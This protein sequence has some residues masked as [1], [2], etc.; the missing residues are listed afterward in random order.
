[1]TGSK[2]F[3][4][5]SWLA[6]LGRMRAPGERFCLSA[7]S[8]TSFTSPA[9]GR[10]RERSERER[11]RRRCSEPNGSAPSSRPSPRARGEG[12]RTRREAILFIRPR[13]HAGEGDHAKHGGGGTRRLVRSDRQSKRRRPRP[14]HRLLSRAVPLPRLAGQ[15][16]RYH[17]TKTER[18]GVA[19]SAPDDVQAMERAAVSR[20]ARLSGAGA[21]HAAGIL[22]RLHQRTLPPRAPLSRAA[23]VLLG[24][25]AG[26]AAGRMG[27][28]GSGLPAAARAVVARFAQRLGRPVV[29]LRWHSSAPA[30]SAGEGT[31]RSAVEGV[32]GGK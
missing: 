27:E 28:G 8:L 24:A 25:Q 10:G 22:A 19:V 20:A 6:K 16:G 2:S 30:R 18:A 13:A 7:R 21:V 23:A 31:A 17:A 12:V 4:A 3:L 26:D 14:F 5:S 15:D 11:D 1:M 32:C 29:V 9:C